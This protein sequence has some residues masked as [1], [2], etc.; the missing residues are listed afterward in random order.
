M[1]PLQ[2]SA[3]VGFLHCFAHFDSATD[4]RQVLTWENGTPNTRGSL[5]ICYARK[6]PPS[7]FAHPLQCQSLRVWGS[8]FETL[9]QT[10][11]FVITVQD[12]GFIDGPAM[13][14]SIIPNAHLISNN[15]FSHANPYYKIPHQPCH[16]HF[17]QVCRLHSE[18]HSKPSHLP[19][20]RK[21]QCPPF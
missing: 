4:H 11:K 8:G 12:S 18:N 19:V 3:R 2:P 17:A 15:L 21:Y 14:Q 7:C 20:S 1:E 16:L 5:Y 13:M 10:V 9:V 6:K